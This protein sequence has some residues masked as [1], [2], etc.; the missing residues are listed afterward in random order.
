MMWSNASSRQGT[1]EAKAFPC[2]SATVAGRGVAFG[3][4]LHASMLVITVLASM[5]SWWWWEDARAI[6]DQAE[7]LAVATVRTESLMAELKAQMTRDALMMSP[8]EMARIRTDVGFLNQ[9][10][11]KRAFS[12]VQLLSDLEATVPLPIAI[13]SVKVNFQ[14][15]TVA[16]NGA[17]H[18]LASL[19]MFVMNLQKH[20]A[21]RKA[22]LVNHHV[23]EDETTQNGHQPRGA[24]KS[25]GDI[26]FTLSAQ[27][28]LQRDGAGE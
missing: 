24:R 16:L 1:G 26:Q 2:L 15:S 8:E 21:F 25:E 12:W 5:L 27:Y 20:E 17:A 9:L 11:E 19:N 10:A 22:A 23:H 4:A 13:S 7:R 14:E 3:R 18:D 28:R 6:E